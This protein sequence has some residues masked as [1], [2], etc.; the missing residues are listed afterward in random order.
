MVT[1]CLESNA[2]EENFGNRGD[3]NAYMLIYIKNV[4]IP[5]A[6]NSSNRPIPFADTIEAVIKKDQEMI[7]S[8]KD[9]L[10]FIVFTPERMGSI[11]FKR[12]GKLFDSRNKHSYIK[13]FIDRS[14][15]VTNLYE[16]LFESLHVSKD[17]TYIRILRLSSKV[18]ID[19]WKKDQLN[20]GDRIPLKNMFN[21]SRNFY[22]W[23]QN[24]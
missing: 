21:K 9:Q 18:E 13:L 24:S 11:K 12:D 4:A 1:K 14:K 10:E 2:I 19:N 22:K 3:T 6:L 16:L 20:E 15:S 5:F 8:M 17:T 7:N 23:N